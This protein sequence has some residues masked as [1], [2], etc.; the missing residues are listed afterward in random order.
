[1]VFIQGSCESFS[2]CDFTSVRLDGPVHV[3]LKVLMDL[4]IPER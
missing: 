4:S 2:V 3:V 1:M